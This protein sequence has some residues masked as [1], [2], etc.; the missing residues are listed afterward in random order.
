MPGRHPASANV[1]DESQPTPALQSP[2]PRSIAIVLVCLSR[3][4]C[5]RLLSRT[6]CLYEDDTSP[7]EWFGDGKSRKN[8][9]RTRPRS[10]V[11]K[12]D[13]A[14]IR[15][16]VANV[17]AINEQRFAKVEVGSEVAEYLAW[18]LKHADAIDPLGAERKPPS[19]EPI[20]DEWTSFEPRGRTWRESSVSPGA[21]NPGNLDCRD[22]A[23]AGQKLQKYTPLGSNQQ[24]SV[25]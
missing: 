11:Q 24:P 15:A 3:R 8:G 5:G 14:C 13:Q 12:W 25:P 2:N 4:G 21:G 16:F 22:A 19:V 20:N 23:G 1:S 10:L 7:H 9:R 18:A 17:Y 6:E